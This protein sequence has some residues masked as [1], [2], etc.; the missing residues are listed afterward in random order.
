[1][2]FGF[3][4]RLCVTFIIVNTSTAIT[5][6]TLMTRTLAMARRYLYCSCCFY[7]HSQIRKYLSSYV[8][9][10]FVISTTN[11]QVVVKNEVNFSFILAFASRKKALHMLKLIKSRGA[12]QWSS[13][14]FRWRLFFVVSTYFYWNVC[15]PHVHQAVIYFIIFWRCNNDH[16]VLSNCK[17][18]L[19]LA[20]CTE[21]Q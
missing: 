20:K 10:S 21:K 3:L 12:L 14:T 15:L 16:S 19:Y 17:R 6:V 7:I 4:P 13:L 1:M 2:F 5:A 18:R 8:K 11:S 9:L